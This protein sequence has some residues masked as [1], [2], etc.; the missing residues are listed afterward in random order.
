LAQ[1]NQDTTLEENKRLPPKT[2]QTFHYGKSKFA[3]DAL[4]DVYLCPGNQELTYRFSTFE[5]ERELR[6]Y[7]ASGCKGCALKPQCTR[8]KASRTITR[9]ENEGLME[10][11]A[12]RVK[13]GRDIMKLKKAIVEHPF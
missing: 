9:E 3:F 4:K 8:N 1:A 2:Y 12:Q 7:R 10:A 6:Y 11:M 13:A 5:K